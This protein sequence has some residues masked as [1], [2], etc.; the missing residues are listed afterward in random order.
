MSERSSN[1]QS[2]SP[3]E[4]ELVEFSV[5]DGETQVY[6]GFIVEKVRSVIKKPKLRQITNSPHYVAG[7]MT[8]KNKD[9]PVIDLGL[10]LGKL[11]S[12][13]PDQILVIEF[14]RVVFG[15]LVNFVSNI[16]SYTWEHNE[17]PKPISSGSYIAG[18]LKGN[19]LSIPI[20]DLERII[21][22]LYQEGIV[23]ALDANELLTYDSFGN[24]LPATGDA[25]LIR[26]QI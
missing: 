9:L 18:L 21:A 22:E 19:N 12:K 5:C 16:Q 15:A 7:M 20:I 13:A 10:I 11:P 6:Y 14:K 26:V 8:L 4:L 24:K 2:S 17:T 3:Q 1:R 23:K 25:S